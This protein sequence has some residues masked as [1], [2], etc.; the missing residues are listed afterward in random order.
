MLDHITL[1][2]N[3]INNYNA[4]HDYFASRIAGDCMN[5]EQS[6]MQIKGGDMLLCRRLD[7]REF[8]SNWQSYK[9]KIILLEPN[10]YNS[11]NINY[12]LVKQFV[13]VLHGWFIVMR[14]YNPPRVFDIP[15]DEV[16]SIAIV[17]QIL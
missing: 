15:A 8:L 7:R 2:K 4:E 17:E 3:E 1:K 16:K 6:P 5:H 14:M 13:E 11:L 9:G 12:S 10:T